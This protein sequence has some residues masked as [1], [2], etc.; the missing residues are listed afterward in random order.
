LRHKEGRR[1]PSSSC[2]DI[3]SQDKA[4][5]DDLDIFLPLV[6]RIRVVIFSF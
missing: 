2:Y 6:G 4:V 5:M 3:R 1:F